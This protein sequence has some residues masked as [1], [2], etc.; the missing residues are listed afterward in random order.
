M[1]Q[2]YRNTEEIGKYDKKLVHRC[3]LQHCVAYFIRISWW[4]GE[5]QYTPQKKTPERTVDLPVHQT[6]H[7]HFLFRRLC[8]LFFRSPRLRSQVRDRKKNSASR[9]GGPRNINKSPEVRLPRQQSFRQ[10]E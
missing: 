5:L 7:K 9:L 1:N 3:R 8:S 2:M 6:P 10:M 4:G